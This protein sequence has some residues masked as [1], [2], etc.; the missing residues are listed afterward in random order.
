VFGQHR[1]VS[2]TVVLKVTIQCIALRGR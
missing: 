1:E 2:D